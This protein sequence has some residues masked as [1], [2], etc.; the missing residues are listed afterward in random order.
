MLKKRAHR[1][2]NIVGTNRA[3][4]LAYIHICN[5]IYFLMGVR[6]PGRTVCAG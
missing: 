6:L 4:S 5:T 3:A 2:Q 1:N